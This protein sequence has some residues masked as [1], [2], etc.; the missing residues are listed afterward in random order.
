MELQD[1]QAKPGTESV[2]GKVVFSSSDIQNRIAEL[3]QQITRDYARKNL[4]VISILRGG[5][6]FLTDL[7]RQINLPLSIDFMGI[8]TYGISDTGGGVVRIT[9]DLEDSIEEK[10]VLIAED[11]ID[12]GLTISYLLRNLKSRYPKSIE[13]CTLLDRDTR[14]MVDVEIKYKGF[15]IGEKY[16]VGYGLDYKQ[17]FRNLDS[18]YEL[19]I[20][21]VKKDIE[22][23]LN[24]DS[25]P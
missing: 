15:S 21:T 18:I 24:G 17:H 8:S 6:I 3:G 20:D 13:I 1:L 22:Q 16:I 9:K 23:S 14:R 12:T 10:D 19:N 2:I 5:V 7:I 4:L 25:R 11:I